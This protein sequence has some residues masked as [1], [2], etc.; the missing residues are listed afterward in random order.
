MKTK[1]DISSKPYNRCLQCRHRHVSC[2][3]PRTASMTLREWCEYM[4]V[5]KEANGLTNTEIAETTG[6]SVKTIEKLLALTYEQDIM[7]ETARKIE[8]AIVGS[9]TLFSCYLAFEENLPDDVPKLKAAFQML[10]GAKAKEGHLLEEIDRLRKE[11]E[12]FKTEND[13]KARIIDKLLDK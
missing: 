11:L 1:T 4:R 8:E 2:N 7:R 3:G 5:I 13:R 6:I 10:E 12:Y 9:A